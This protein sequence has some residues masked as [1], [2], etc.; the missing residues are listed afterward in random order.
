MYPF[1]NIAQLSACAKPKDT[2]TLAAITMAP[3]RF[4]RSA[5][6]G[7]ASVRTDIKLA[8]PTG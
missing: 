8:L 5:E 4:G 2:N 7:W 1:R 6:S 3:L